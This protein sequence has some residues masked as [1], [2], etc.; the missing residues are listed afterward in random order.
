M[1]DQGSF[2]V[3]TLQKVKRRLKKGTL[4]P[5]DHATCHARIELKCVHVGSKALR[6]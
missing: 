1:D 5:Q 6:Q 2:I 3:L 4:F